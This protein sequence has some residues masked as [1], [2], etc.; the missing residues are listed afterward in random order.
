FSSTNKCVTYSHKAEALLLEE[1]VQRH[2]H[3]H[4]HHHHQT[5]TAAAAAAAATATAATAAA[6]VRLSS[7]AA[8]SAATA[9]AAASASN[10]IS[11]SSSSAVCKICLKTRFA[12][13]QGQRC[14]YCQAPAC[15]R[16]ASAQPQ[17][18]PAGSN[19]T[20]VIILHIC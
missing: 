9:T 3:H 14:F 13:G 18:P 4:H 5:A 17:P 20:Q 7:S 19:A 10:S 15:K 2:H 1:V 16:C 12:D 11:P 6:A 8:I